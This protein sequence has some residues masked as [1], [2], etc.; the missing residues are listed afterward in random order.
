MATAP[1]FIENNPASIIAEVVALY[2]QESGKTLLPAQVERLLLGAFAYRETILRAQVQA[3]AVQNLVA[4]ASAPALDYLGQLVGVERLAPAPALCTLNFTLVDGH[5]GVVIPANTRV[6]SADGKVYFST[7]QN[8]SVPAGETSAN[9]Q[10]IAF[11]DG[12]IGNDFAPG[13]ITDILDPQPFITEAENTDIT[14]GGADAES[15]D[16]L[17]ERILLAPA[18]FSTAGSRGAYVFHAKSASQT[19]LDVAVIQIE[20]GT[21]GIYPFTGALPTPPEILSLVETIC[22]AEKVRP[23]TDT[24]QVNSPIAV[25]YDLEIELTTYESADQDSTLADAQASIAAYRDSRE[26]VLGKDITVSQL[27]AAAHVDGVYS[28]T[29]ISPASDLFIDEV[30]VPVAN[31][32]SVTIT[33]TANG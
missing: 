6:A 24:V 8:V 16:R 5:S 11:P 17:R 14:V 29:V 21:V 4:F 12:V 1:T 27:V 30:E 20:P 3:A 7:L 19:I 33:G 23:L 13:E 22:S 26:K 28:V 25:S 2:E 18:S 10:A 31:T 15:D 9:A 32:V